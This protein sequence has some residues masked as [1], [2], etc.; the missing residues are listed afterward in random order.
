M[1]A[2][3]T[4]TWSPDVGESETKITY[5]EAWESMPSL[6]RLDNLKDALEELEIKYNHVLETEGVFGKLGEDAA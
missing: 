3:I 4:I 1:K 6:T 2:Q 5:S